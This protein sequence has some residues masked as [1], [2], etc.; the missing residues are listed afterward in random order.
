MTAVSTDAPGPGHRAGGAAMPFEP[1]PTTIAY[2]LSL[3]SARRARIDGPGGAPAAPWSDVVPGARWGLALSGGG[4]RSATFA[5]GVLQAI[6]EAP[7]PQSRPAQDEPG[8]AR[9]ATAGAVFR[10]SLLSRF[11]YLS[12]V[13]G[14]GYIGAFLCSLFQPD[15]LRDQRNDADRAADDAV[16]VLQI[17]APGRIH[18]EGSYEGD[19]RLAVPLAWL[20]ENGRYL[21]P[22][23][24]GDALYAA[25]LGI[26]NWMA[27][28]FVIGTALLALL[29]ALALARAALLR[30]TQCWEVDWLAQAVRGA[31]AGWGLA[32]IWWSPALLAA[33][34]LLFLWAV[35]CGI[36]FWCTY[37]GKDDISRPL[38]RAALC[39][40]LVSVL[41]VVCAW[42]DGAAWPVASD[43]CGASAQRWWLWLAGAAMTALGVIYSIATAVQHPKIAD[44]RVFLTRHL[45]AACTAMGV[46]LAVGVIDSAGQTLYLLAHRPGGAPLLTFP[47][48]LAALVWLAKKGAANFGKP[49]GGS[50]LRK[51]PLTTLGGLAGVLILLLVACIWSLTAQWLAWSGKKPDHPLRIDDLLGVW[52]LVPPALALLVGQFPG[53]INL[54][55]LQSF[56]SARLVRAYLGASNRRRFEKRGA[57]LS[58]AEPI[59]GDNL[60]PQ[61][62][63]K[64][65]PDGG[66]PRALSTLAPLHIVNVTLSKT[67]D[68][69]EQLV[70]RDRKGQPLAVLP[71]GFTVEG[72]RH[73]FP[74]REQAYNEV[75]RP[76]SVGQW[77]GTSGAAVAT[78]IGRETSLG[79]SLLMGAAN[80]RLGVWWESGAGNNKPV[81]GALSWLTGAL[82]FLFRTQTYLSYEFRARFFGLRRKWQYLSDGGH[83]ENTG[84][85]ELLRPERRVGLVL[86]TDGGADPNYAFG[87]L[88]NLIRLVRIDFGVELSVVRDFKAWPELGAIFGAPEDFAPAAA[89]RTRCAV[90]LRAVPVGDNRVASWVVLL[91][92]VV[93]HA[94]PADIRQYALT[95]PAFP[96]EP[97]ADQFFDEAQWESYRSLGF[98]TAARVLAP[99]TWDALARYVQQNPHV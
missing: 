11:D 75:Q 19:E 51:L 92:P 21:V 37:Q 54:S 65:R 41:L 73:A 36:G 83:F 18:A 72:Y 53:F 33:P 43:A 61:D 14:G 31:D 71:F 20:R 38:N 7:A 50:L 64:F 95:R 55:S 16:R 87:D 22:T 24:F 84:L 77:I 35:P 98:A 78:G 60:Q 59:D 25:A 2:E 6:A 70:Q 90:L 69:A 66:Q 8:A 30:W 80:V 79:M 4:I 9:G 28:H 32:A 85:Y 23:G 81:T 63:L 42:Q 27:L 17:G 76:L 56:Y 3:V 46:V 44:Q 58:V 67:V 1:D 68:P 94:A 88:A 34:L 13:S 89:A 97:T 47:A 49:A 15:R 45:A 40:A 74:V 26:R 62:Y 82:G 99:A 93:G 48:L 39:G 10:R 12:T 5:L 57:A 52:L 86:A 29:I 96:Q 91:K